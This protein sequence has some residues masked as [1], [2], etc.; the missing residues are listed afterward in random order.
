MFRNIIVNS[1]LAAVGLLVSVLGSGCSAN[2]A[3]TAGFPITR[4]SLEAGAAISFSSGTYVQ[5]T[6]NPVHL[7]DFHFYEVHPGDAF[8]FSAKGYLYQ[9][10]FYNDEI[11]GNLIHTYCYSPEEN[12]ATYTGNLGR[13]GWRTGNRLFSEHGWARLVLRRIDGKPV[14][15]E[16]KAYIEQHCHF[17]RRTVPYE[18]KACF[19]A[20][21]ADTADKVNAI[22]ND[23]TLVFGLLTDNHYVINGHWEDTAYNLQAVHQKAPFNALIHLGDFTDGMVPLEITKE[24]F[25]T[26][27][28]DLKKLSVPL[29]LVLG[30][31]DSNYFRN[32]PQSLTAD[33]QSR[34][35]LG[36]DLPY[37]FVD[38]AEKKLRMLV[39]YS[40]DHTQEGQNNRYGF[41]AEE[42]AWVKSVLDTV[43]VD[44]KVLVCS[45]VPLLASMH[46][47]SDEIRNGTEMVQVLEAFNAGSGGGAKG[48]LLAFIHGH[49]HSDWVNTTDLS[50]PIVAVGCAKI[51]DDQEKKAPGSTTYSRTVGDVTQELWDVLVVNTRTG[52]LDFVRFGAGVDRHLAG[53]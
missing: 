35:Y 11:D 17:A 20:E 9:L 25:G 13:L 53:E 48:R 12:W 43:P 14:T 23:D 18:E 26:I 37:Y 49:I 28:A 39:L 1:G 8:L 36:N 5:E 42:V 24:Y 6:K 2:V 30:N 50:F 27:Y 44:Y 3:S 33:E 34:L 4:P 21:I 22:R 7:A 16:D 51:E 32:N 19:T 31:H 46:F 40:F 52:Q 38:F 15:A 10:A 47:W 45:H 29:Y 41:P